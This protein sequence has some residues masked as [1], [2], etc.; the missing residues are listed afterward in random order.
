M[1]TLGCGDARLDRVPSGQMIASPGAGDRY[2][3]HQNR[4]HK[5]PIDR[6]ATPP[7]AQ[8]PRTSIVAVARFPVQA[9]AKEKS[10]SGRGVKLPII[11][12]KLSK[13]PA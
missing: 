1:M 11:F 9:P 6:H 7:P 10:G 8:S 3:E 13:S 2:R 5:P 12:N 4:K